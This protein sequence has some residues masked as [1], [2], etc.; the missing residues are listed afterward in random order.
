VHPLQHYLFGFMD[1]WA[2]LAANAPA[3]AN[4]PMRT[5]GLRSLV[6]AI[7]GV[8]PQRELPQFAK[9]SFQSAYRTRGAAG[10]AAT[11]LLLWP[12]TWNN[13]FH[14]QVL[15]AAHEV[16]ASAGFQVQFPAQHICCGRPLYDFGFLDQARKYLQEILERLG[17]QIDSGMPFVVLEPSC[18]SVFRDELTNFFPSNER[19]IR[20]AKQTFLLSEFLT[21]HV[22][23]YQPPQLAGRQIV[24]HGHCHHKALMG[25]QDER[26]LLEATN[27]QV[28]MLDSGC[29]GMAGPFGFEK[30]KFEVSQALG[31]R[32]LLPAVR[33]A[34]PETILVT[35]GFSCREQIRQN[36]PRHAVHLAEVLAGRC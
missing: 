28:S 6:K 36:T 31:E 26:S 29:C 23:G 33:S 13:Y 11:P 16:L 18:A 7:A 20:L 1:R 5:P 27:A 34:S 30:D 32:V 10:S 17:P 2:H 15:G 35:D 4:L 14:P 21:R 8:A 24:L 22:P 19:A 25:M 3:L 9:R 12:D